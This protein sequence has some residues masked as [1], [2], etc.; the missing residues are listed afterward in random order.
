MRYNLTDVT[1][2]IPVRID[3]VFRLE[4]LVMTTRFLRQNF[5]C[6]IMVT[7]AA[8]Y[9]NGIIPSLLDKKT[10]YTFVPDIDEIF[11]RTRYLNLMTQKATT[12]FLAIWDTDVIVPPA[13]MLDAIIQLKAGQ[14]EFAIPYDGNALDTSPVLREFFLQTGDWQFLARHKNKMKLLYNNTMKGGGLFVNREA[15]VHSGMENENFYGWGPEDFERVA[16]WKGLGYRLHQS[17][18]CLYHLSHPRSMNSSFRSVGQALNTSSEL[19]LTEKS[20]REELLEHIKAGYFSK[21]D[22]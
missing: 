3:S 13:Q 11:Y 20:S 15:Y 6:R 19:T 2:M 10:E 21:Q 7:E 18:G 1:F 4:N 5:D 9:A 17:E 8:R 16:R 14:A 12:P 22:R